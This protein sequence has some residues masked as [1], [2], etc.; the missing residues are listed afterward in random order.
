MKRTIPILGAM[1]LGAVLPQAEV[2]V[3]LVRWLVAWMLFAV[4]LRTPLS[5]EILHRSHFVLLAANFGAGFA[6][7]RLGGWWGGRDVALAAFFCG[8]TPTAIAAPVIVSFL[9][10]RVSYVTG[11]FLLS[12]LAVAAALPVILPF[13]LGRPTPGLFSQVA[14]SMGGM[15]FAPFAVAWF[16]RR[17]WAG[18]VDWAATLGNLNFGLWVVAIFLI[19][20]NASNFLRSQSDLDFWVVVKIAFSSLLT[21][22][23]NFSGGRWIGGREFSAEASQSLGQ[24]N[25]TFT[26]YLA[27]AYES[28]LVALGPTF[29][30][31]WHNLWNAWQL[32]RAGKVG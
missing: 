18:A 27:M 23:A 25:T 17:C 20:A 14:Q 4:F 22:A 30:V 13:V 29:Y 2:A 10:G 6:A 26:I 9:R 16:L 21:C 24:K 3:G 28:P 1:L 19:T 11:A 7:W 32:H 31:I 5:R 15:V 8:I 12:N